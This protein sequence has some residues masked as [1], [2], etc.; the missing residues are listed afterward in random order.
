MSRDIK[1]IKK[2]LAI[3]FSVI[4]F[5]VI[6]FLGI[7]FF[8]AKYYNQTRIEKTDFNTLINLVET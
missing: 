6:L 7:I 2:K 3:M 1:I 8:S 4:V 5:V